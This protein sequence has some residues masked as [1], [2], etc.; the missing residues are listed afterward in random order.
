MLNVAKLFL[1][2][3]TDF[4]QPYAKSALDSIVKVGLRFLARKNKEQNKDNSGEESQNENNL[5]TTQITIESRSDHNLFQFFD[6][7]EEIENCPMDIHKKKSELQAEVT[8]FINYLKKKPLK[9]VKSTSKF[10][11]KYQTELSNLYQLS[12]ILLN[13]PSSSAYIERFFS[14][15][16]FFFDKRRYNMKPELTIKRCLL[17]ANID[18]L[19]ELSQETE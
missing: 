9:E 4:A 1:W 8:K 6:H 18:I 14:I 16:G 15:C 10:W 11:Y 7:E 17:A 2:F 5:D 12:L 13:I 3:Q 19:N